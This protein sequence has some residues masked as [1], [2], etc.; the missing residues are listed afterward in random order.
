MRMPGFL[1]KTMISGALGVGVVASAGGVAHAAPTAGGVLTPTLTC[2]INNPNGS[3][4]AHFGYNDSIP[5]NTYIPPGSTNPPNYFTPGSTVAGQPQNFFQGSYP[6]F[7]FVTEPNATNVTWTLGTGV[8]TATA[9]STP[10][11]PSAILP[12]VPLAI[13]LPASAAGIIGTWTLI[14]RRRRRGAVSV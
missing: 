1:A 12:E 9:G 14:V 3:Y 4:T 11:G 8:S 6:D 5:G 10:C 13:A 2:V 7:L